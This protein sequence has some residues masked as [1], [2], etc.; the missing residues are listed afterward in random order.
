[1]SAEKENPT[2]FWK[3]IKKMQNWGSDKNDLSDNI[4]PKEWMLHFQKLLNSARVSRSGSYINL[5]TGFESCRI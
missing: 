3:V 5:P 4:D 1:M 2:E